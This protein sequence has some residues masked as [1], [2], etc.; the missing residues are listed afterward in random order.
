[1]KVEIRRMRDLA[2]RMGFPGVG[3]DGFHIEPGRPTDGGLDVVD[4]NN[5]A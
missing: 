2:R 5:A 1:M 4:T 3:R